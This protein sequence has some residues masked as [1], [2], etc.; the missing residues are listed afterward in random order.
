MMSQVTQ[1][2]RAVYRE[3]RAGQFE[4][5]WAACGAAMRSLERLRFA[6]TAGDLEARLDALEQ[7]LNRRDARGSTTNGYVDDYDDQRLGPWQ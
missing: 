3:A 2:M 1:E 7:H 5:G 4:G 6:L